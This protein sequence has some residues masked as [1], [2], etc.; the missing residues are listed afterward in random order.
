MKNL[1]FYLLFLFFL[2]GCK[3]F[4]TNDISVT[5]KYNYWGD[6]CKT[7]CHQIKIFIKNNTKEKIYIKGDKQIVNNRLY[8]WFKKPLLGKLYY[9]YMRSFGMSSNRDSIIYTCKCG[10]WRTQKEPPPGFIEEAEKRELEIYRSINDF[11]CHDS[12]VKKDNKIWVDAKYNELIIFLSPNEECIIGCDY[13]DYF[14]NPDE[15]YKIYYLIGKRNRGKNDY[16]KF[17]DRMNNRTMKRWGGYLK[18][19]AGYKF[20]EGKAKSNTLVIKKGE[21]IKNKPAPK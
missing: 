10:G 21:V 13:L 16:Y 11:N 20:F 14:I 19:I 7:Y 12:I 8:T 6:T 1:I 15:K 3:S 2:S 5:A 4:Y 9:G 17:K 18:E